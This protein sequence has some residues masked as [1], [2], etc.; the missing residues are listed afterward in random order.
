MLRSIFRFFRAI[1]YLL[2]GRVDKQTSKIERDPGVIRATTEKIIQDKKTRINEYKE[3]VATLIAQQEKKTLTL[4]RLSDEVIK[5][6]DRQ[7]GAGLKAKERSSVLQLQGIISPEL[8]KSDSI[9]LECQAAFND[10]SSTITEKEARIIELENDIKTLSGTI[11]NHQIQLQSL[12]REIEKIKEESA[13][14]VADV[15]SSA[16][17]KAINDAMSG[18]SQDD[19]ESQLVRLR[20][21]RA[22][23]KAEAKVARDLNGSDAK[24]L[25][26]QYEQFAQ[27]AKSN[28]EFDA[29]LGL[30]DDK[31]KRLEEKLAH[32]KEP[33]KV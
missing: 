11:S 7:T 13:D 3:A 23:A 15:I 14:I 6:R 22:Q 24:H 2:T 12:S 5:L 4:K 9:I 10:F 29:M 17:E 27:S 30:G 20:E 1:G 8:I 16:E 18:I 32:L 19:S 31:V 33:E 28:V 21:M 26:A 25:E